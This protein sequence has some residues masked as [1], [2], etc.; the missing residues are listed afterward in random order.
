MV[1]KR[2]QEIHQLPDCLKG[3]EAGDL[4]F[5][6]II[7]RFCESGFFR[8]FGVETPWRESLQFGFVEPVWPTPCPSEVNIRSFGAVN[9]GLKTRGRA[10]CWARLRIVERTRTACATE[11]RGIVPP[12]QHSHYEQR[13]SRTWTVASY[14]T[15]SN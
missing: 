10:G 14:F 1:D 12:K 7:R 3:T 5:Y 4:D 6:V 11:C 15:R 13:K 8:W 9:L 2:S